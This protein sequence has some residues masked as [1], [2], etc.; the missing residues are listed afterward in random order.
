[1]RR[2]TAGLATG[3]EHERGAE[4][5]E[6]FVLFSNTDEVPELISD[7]LEPKSPAIDVEQLALLL[8]VESF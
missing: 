6:E 8:S 3:V 1:M 7:G 5:D 4:T 2:L